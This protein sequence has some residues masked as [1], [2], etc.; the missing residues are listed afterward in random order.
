M[1]A[2]RSALGRQGS[3]GPS[4]SGK[5]DPS[6]GGR[7]FS[8]PS[9][10][11]LEHRAA[12]SARV[13]SGPEASG[14]VQAG[15]MFSVDRH[16]RGAAATVLCGCSPI[17]EQRWSGRSLREFPP[18]GIGMLWAVCLTRLGSSVILILPKLAGALGLVG[19]GRP[20][21]TNALPT[22]LLTIKGLE[23]EPLHIVGWP[24]GVLCGKMVSRMNWH[25][26]CGV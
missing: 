17:P 7:L 14:P 13:D 24:T 21:A 9:N 23:P 22:G 12:T 8:V 6:W 2:S 18:L 15:P 1:Q 5:I 4:R 25:C 11:S 19:W 3:V 16:G 26:L 10:G 20:D